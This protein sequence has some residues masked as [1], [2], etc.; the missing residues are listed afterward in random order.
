MPL[1]FRMFSGIDMLKTFGEDGYRH[2]ADATTLLEHLIY[3][4]YLTEGAIQ[5]SYR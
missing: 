2:E 5:F 4:M 1:D 3:V